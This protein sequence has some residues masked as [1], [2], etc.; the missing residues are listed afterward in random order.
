[1]LI[2]TRLKL[3]GKRSKILGSRTITGGKNAFTNRV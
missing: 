3:Y 1:M 2:K